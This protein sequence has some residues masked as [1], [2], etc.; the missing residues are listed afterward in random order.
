MDQDHPVRGGGAGWAPFD[1][2][3][4]KGEYIGVTRDLY[5][6][7]HAEDRPAIRL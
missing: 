6:P 3:D 1:M 7:D 2:V 4:D 5:R